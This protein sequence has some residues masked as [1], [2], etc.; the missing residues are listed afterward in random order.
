LLPLADDEADGLL[1]AV[2]EEERGECWW[3]V[4]RDGRP[5][6][7]DRGGGV[8]LFAEVG[9]TR[10]LGRLLRALRLSR[11]VDASDRLVSR[12]RARLGRFVPDGRAPRRYP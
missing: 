7:G 12:H 8:A 5:V 11:L 1:G 6:P 10:P 2:P 3:L 4:L 9:L